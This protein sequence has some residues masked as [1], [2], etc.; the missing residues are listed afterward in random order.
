MTAARRS[1]A[2]LVVALALALAAPASTAGDDPLLGM[3]NRDLHF[4]RQQLR[5]TLVEV[6]AGAYPQETGPD[7]R[8]TTTGPGRWT[9]GFLAGS[10]WLMYQA[11]GDPSWSRAAGARQAGLAGEQSNRSTHDLGFILFDSFGKG[12]RLTA[13]DSY[14]RVVLGAARSVAS[15]YRRSVR[16]IR[17][18]NNPPRTP[19]SDFRVVIDSLMNL[20]LLFWA[21]QHGGGHRLA[22]KARKHAL[23][24]ARVQVRPNGSTYHLVIY[25]GRTGAVKRRTTAQGYRSSSTWSRGQAWALYGFGTVYADTRDARMLEAARRT[26][27]YFLAHLPA[28]RVPYWDFNA[29]GIPHEPRDSSAA[30]IAASGLLQ[31][32][33]L[34]S[35]PDR[36][37]RYLAT[38]R[39]ILSSLSSKR[40]L[41]AGTASRSILLHGTAD[42]PSG[43]YNTGLIYGDYYFIEALLRY[44]EIT[45]GV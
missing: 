41:A 1:T 22:S 20:D 4:A 43:H 44:R 37:E 11:S 9:S 27:D 34:E 45:T 24:T 16:A 31:L 8:W 15:R 13:A 12:Y 33:Q 39:E 19:R 18:W 35:D 28:D 25:N 30:A 23:R 10:L 6:P 2:V 14:R 17:S 7:G 42:R 29:P 38:A 32:S 5:R 36:A 26:A 40:Y 21:S 3:V